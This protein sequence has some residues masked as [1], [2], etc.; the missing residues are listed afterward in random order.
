[1]DLSALAA[2]FKSCSAAKKITRDTLCDLL[3]EGL[4]YLEVNLCNNLHKTE[5]PVA[6]YMIQANSNLLT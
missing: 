6:E 4:L 1:M 2:V 5:E 3:E